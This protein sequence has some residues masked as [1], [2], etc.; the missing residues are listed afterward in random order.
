MSV[1]TEAQKIAESYSVEELP[2][3]IDA[4]IDRDARY[5]R[6]GKYSSPLAKF[7]RACIRALRAKLNTI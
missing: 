2:P 1:K 5:D 3:A 6:E 4:S 7:N